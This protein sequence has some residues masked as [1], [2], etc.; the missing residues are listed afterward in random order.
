MTPSKKTQK[1]GGTVGPS[2]S[3]HNNLYIPGDRVIARRLV[4]MTG[5]SIAFPDPHRL[6]HLQFRRFA[7]CPICNLH[8][9]PFIQRKAELDAAG[10]QELIVFHSTAEELLQNESDVPFPVIPDPD[11]LLY[12]EFRVGTSWR[13]VLDPGAMASV[14]RGAA[15]ALSRRFTI[16][17]PLPL[18]PATNGR[19]GLP[20]DFLITTDSR[21]AA[22]KYGRHSGDSWSVDEVL[23]LASAEQHA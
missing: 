12:N 13:S 2:T 16:K 20:A 21:V 14:P 17:A 15:L 5:E 3:S 11:K 6:I 19:T 7:G 8:L 10:V 18:R 9:R 1:L 22:V 4:S 23:A